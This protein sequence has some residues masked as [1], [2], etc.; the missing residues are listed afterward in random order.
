MAKYPCR[1]GGVGGGVVDGMRG[2]KGFNG[3]SSPLNV[4]DYVR[5]R[6]TPANYQNFRCQCYFKLSEMVNDR[7]I[8]VKI[9]KFTTNIEGYTVEKAISEMI[10]ELDVIQKTDNSID[11][12]LAIIPKSEIKELLG[13]SP[14]FADIFMMRMF[15]ELKD[16]PKHIREVA[17]EVEE[18]ETN[19]AM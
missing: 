12:K 5:S 13:R 4:W 10:E 15:F 19:I 6:M 7:N 9:T 14:D 16:T 11:S 17:Y 8:L 18:K 1:R 3:A 2:I